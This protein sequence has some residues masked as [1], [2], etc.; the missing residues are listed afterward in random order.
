MDNLDDKVR[1]KLFSIIRKTKERI[2]GQWFVKLKYSNEIYEFRFDESGRFYRLFA[3]WDNEGEIETLIVS[4]HGII[5]KTNKT[6]R[7]E[8]NKA[9]KIRKR[10][11]DN[12][13][14]K[15]KLE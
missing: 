3:F 7:E 15:I 6:P 8:I 11:F 9:E 2:V 5:K 1:K 13:M 10:Y 4:T 14:L 12:K